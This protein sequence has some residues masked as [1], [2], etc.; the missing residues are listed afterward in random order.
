MLSSER[1]IS[2]AL[3]LGATQSAVLDTDRLRVYP[4]VRQ[5][6]ER[7]SCGSYNSNWMCPP[8]VGSLAETSIRLRE[9]RVGLLIQSVFP[10]E[11]S[12][13]V[14]GMTAAVERHQQLLRVMAKH[15][16]ITYGFE[17]VLPLGTG[18][19]RTCT[20]CSALDDIPCRFPNRALASIEAY[21]VNV[22][23]IVESCG[24]SHTNGPNTVSYV[25]VL[26]YG[27]TAITTRYDGDPSVAST[28]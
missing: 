13:D 3:A 19:C 27:R 4:E 10:L 14:E 23:E 22:K 1:L 2:D 20:R 21:G 26:L 18:P 7:N 16:R 28:A 11:E 9:Y 24:F 12:F 6:C 15:M 5:L 17:R 8:Y 25:G